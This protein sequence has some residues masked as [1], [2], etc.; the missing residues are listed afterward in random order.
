MKRKIIVF[1][2]LLTLS[3]SPIFA[4]TFA[5]DHLSHEEKVVLINKIKQVFKI[6]ESL[7]LQSKESNSE[8]DIEVL[9]WETEK[10][11]LEKK[12]NA[13][14]YLVVDLSSNEIILEKNTNFSY[15]IASM[16]K[17]MSALVALE[18]TDPEEEILLSPEMFL[19]NSYQRPSLSFYSG[20]SLTVRDIVSISLIQS[21][22]NASQSLAHIVGE[23]E[24]IKLMNKRAEEIGM[25]K[26][27]F[28]DPHGLS[29]RNRSSAPDIVKLL[30]YIS[31]EK[32][33][34]LELTTLTDYRPPSRTEITLANLNLFHGLPEFNGGKTGWIPD[35]KQTFAGLFKFNEKPYAI[36]LLYCENRRSDVQ[37]IS[38]WLKRR[39]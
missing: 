5:F 29:D 23:E 13:M 20:A 18:N 12:L 22:N 19:Q 11:S 31:K 14:S 38:E 4:N 10:E 15:P 9:K 26:T 35:S 1:V 2:L 34:I 33:E 24:F 7:R 6:L 30:T 17:L 39:P 8:K 16:T 32:P 25:E 27:R 3:F 28:F 37:E 36:V 21:T